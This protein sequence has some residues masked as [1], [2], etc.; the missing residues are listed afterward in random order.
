MLP[1]RSSLSLTLPCLLALAT[2]T[3]AETRFLALSD[4]HYGIRAISKQWGHGN[5]TS[6]TLWQNAQT[7]AKGL[8]APQSPAV[9]VYLGDMPAH[10]E[11]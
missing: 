2:D 3:Q 10:S 5:E 9:T 4:V 1:F 11:P 7:N 6:L 8:I